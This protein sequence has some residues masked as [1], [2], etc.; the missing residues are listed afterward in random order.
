MLLNL[1]K[2]IWR[3]EHA[4][5]VCGVGVLH[6]GMGDELQDACATHDVGYTVHANATGDDDSRK[7][8]DKRF[9][10]NMKHIVAVGEYN[11]L[12]KLSH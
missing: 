4:K 8:V 10:S 7:D 12:M 11:L 9:L 6:T 3:R 1:I 2:K 5:P